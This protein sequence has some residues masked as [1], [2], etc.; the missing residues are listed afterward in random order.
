MTADLKQAESEADEFR[1]K[2]NIQMGAVPQED[3]DE[4]D[5]PAKKSEGVLA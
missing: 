4:D 2:Y 1:A 3:Q 5:K